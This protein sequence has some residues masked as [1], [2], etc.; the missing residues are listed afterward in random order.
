MAL[1]TSSFKETWQVYININIQSLPTSSESERFI[2]HIR[3][4]EHKHTFFTPKM[5]DSYTRQLPLSS[6]NSAPTICCSLS[7]LSP[8]ASARARE[9]KAAKPGKEEKQSHLLEEN[10]AAFCISAKL[11]NENRGTNI[12]ASIFLLN[13]EHILYMK[14]S[15]SS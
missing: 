12:S 6:V 14:E 15:Y 2:F 10:V 8:H 11:A 9:H 5:P 3:D 1:H 7:E 4:V 13:T